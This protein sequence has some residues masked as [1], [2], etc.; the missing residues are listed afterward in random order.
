MKLLIKLCVMISLLGLF[1]CT[2]INST[3]QIVPG[4]A[5]WGIVPFANNTEIPQAGY[6]AMSMTMGLLEV[7]GIQN[8]IQYKA[9]DSCNQLIVCPNSNPSPPQILSWARAHQLQFVMTGTV[10]EWVYKV[11]LDG[12]PVAS[13]ALQL[14]DVKSGRMIW[15]ALGS[16]FGTTRSGLG[17][18]GQKLIKEMLCTLK[19]VY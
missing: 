5:R 16:K 19:V 10:N 2:T 12:E 7:K 9:N 15:N 1:A 13:V 3:T 18:T 14:Y 17:S 11:G 4:H 6:R 8:I